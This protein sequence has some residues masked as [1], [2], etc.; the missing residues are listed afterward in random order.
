M[1]AIIGPSAKHA[2]ANIKA[3]EQMPWTTEEY[4]QLDAQFENLASIPNYPGSYII[5]RYTKFAFLAAID[6]KADPTTELRK[7]ITTINK[8]IIR[9]R[10]EFG[11]ETLEIGETLV[12][13]RLQE[14]KTALAALSSSDKTQYSQEIANVN[15]AISV[16]LDNVKASNTEGIDALNASIE[17]LKAADS[18]K[19][20]NIIK[21]LEGAAKT[22]A[23]YL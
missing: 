22:L 1:V 23:T 12:E 16:V 8:E 4:S 3:L 18:A 17:Q 2:T 7:Y 6:D 11:L 13:K 5:G 19:F 21:Y 10:A 14:T 20:A 9:K 15:E